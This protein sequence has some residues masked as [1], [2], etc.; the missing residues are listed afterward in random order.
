MNLSVL[1]KE[2]DYQMQLINAHFLPMSKMYKLA[3]Q[4]TIAMLIAKEGS[5]NLTRSDDVSRV[6]EFS[7]ALI[8]HGVLQNFWLGH[9]DR[10]LYY[11][12]KSSASGEC[13]HYMD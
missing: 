13:E 9:Y 5:S 1:K 10:C 12:E 7:E 11:A 3:W 2:C 8:F 6:S 4:E